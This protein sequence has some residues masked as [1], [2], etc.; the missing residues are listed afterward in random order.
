MD[1]CISVVHLFIGLRLD[2]GARKFDLAGG[3][4]GGVRLRLLA[5]KFVFVD[6]M[7]WWGGAPGEAMLVL[8]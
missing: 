7:F 6:T 5:I 3:G 8:S 2:A 1:Y 4:L